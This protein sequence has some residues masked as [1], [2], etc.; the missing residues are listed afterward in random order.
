MLRLKRRERG[1][2]VIL[3][4]SGRLMGGPD[5]DSFQKTIRELIDQGRLHVVVDLGG[6]AWINS[7]GLGMLIASYTSLKDRGGCLKFMNVSRRIEQILQVTKLNTVFE[8]YP[9]EE[10][11]VG[12]FNT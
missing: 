11:V 7:S 3:E 6:V 12:S 2:V 1:N 9:D 4:L 5:S 8:S 10:S